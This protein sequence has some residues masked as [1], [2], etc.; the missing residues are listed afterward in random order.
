MITKSGIQHVWK[1]WF[2]D[3]VKINWSKIPLLKILFPF[4]SMP[5]AIGW[6]MKTPKFI[7]G[8]ISWI[9]WN[10]MKNSSVL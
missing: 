7:R 5:I 3:S 4:S 9:V 8:P 10:S 2:I 1:L 6:Y